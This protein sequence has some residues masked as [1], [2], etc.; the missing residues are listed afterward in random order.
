[1]NFPSEIDH[2]LQQIINYLK[3]SGCSKILLFGSLA[4]ND[5]TDHSDIDIAVT[6]MSP[7]EFLKAVSLLPYIIQH[8]VDIIDLNDLPDYYRK[9]IESNSIVLY[10]N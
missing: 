2:K 6:G 8:K 7:A 5:F 9:E 4:E 1:M 3:E 10:G